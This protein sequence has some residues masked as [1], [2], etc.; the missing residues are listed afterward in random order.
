MLQGEYVAIAQDRDGE[1]VEV[2]RV[3][4]VQRGS[5]IVYEVWSVSEDRLVRAFPTLQEAM[6]FGRELLAPS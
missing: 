6:T 2:G 1:T 5:E 3:F 4:R